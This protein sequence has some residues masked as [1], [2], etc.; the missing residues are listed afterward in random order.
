MPLYK[1]KEESQ[2]RLAIWEISEPESFFIERTG[3][4]AQSKWE[5]R[6]LEFQAS[7]Y[8]L[9]LLDPAF[10]FGNIKI[11]E[12]GKPFLPGE[13][14]HFSITHSF[15]FVGVALA[16]MPIGIDVQIYQ[17]KISRLQQ[18]FLSEEEQKYF[19]NDIRQITLAWAA[20]EAVFKW[21]GLSGIDFK[22]HMPIHDFQVLPTTQASM[23]ISFEK[24]TPSQS[25]L[26]SGS[27]EEQFGWMVTVPPNS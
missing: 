1:I 5:H 15:P 14:A 19:N 11:S 10:P 24:T 22:R 12:Q 8:L 21:S 16:T 3:L 23:K 26:L 9:K 6:R 13:N 18:K 20:K 17:E 27:I 4:I 2:Y 7:R 25:L